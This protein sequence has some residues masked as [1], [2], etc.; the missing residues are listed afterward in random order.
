ML[1]QGAPKVAVQ[2]RRE[3]RGLALG[4]LGGASLLWSLIPLAL[5]FGA[6]GA[7]FLNAG[8]WR[9]AAS[10]PLA[11]TLALF[12]RSRLLSPRRLRALGRQLFSRP[13][14]VNFGWASSYASYIWSL[15]FIDVSMATVLIELWPI[16]FILTMGRIFRYGGSRPGWFLWPV[17]AMAFAGAAVLVFSEEGRIT[18]GAGGWR[19]AAG[20]GLA[21]LTAALSVCSSGLFVWGR[22]YAADLDPEGREPGLVLQGTL[23]ATILAQ[24]PVGLLFLGLGW[25]FGEQEGVRVSLVSVAGGLVL[26]FPGLVMFR[27]GNLVT[28]DFSVNLVSYLTPLGALLWLWT[29]GLVGVARPDLLALGAVLVVLANLL[30]NL[31]PGPLSRARGLCCRR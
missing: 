22:R 21:L 16:L 23:A 12:Y 20:V 14:L 15:R 24:V 30:I 29:F 7:P 1:G 2:P 9:L 28:R 18:L 19:L 8:L 13:S 10:V 4:L 5:A 26:S 25:A 17:L 31:G 3:A 6:A 27:V 11:L